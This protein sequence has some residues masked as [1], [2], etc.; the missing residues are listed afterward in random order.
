MTRIG[1]T[2][3]DPVTRTRG[4]VVPG[5]GVPTG[6]A[7][8]SIGTRSSRVPNH[9]RI[10]SAGPDP[11][12][13]RLGPPSSWYQPVVGSD[14]ARYSGEF[15]RAV[16][17]R[18]RMLAVLLALTTLALLA[19]VG[20]TRLQVARTSGPRPVPST[21]TVVAVL[22]PQL[23][24][25]QVTTPRPT[26]ERY[27]VRAGDTLDRIAERFG[28]AVPAIVA[29]NRL[30]TPDHLTIGQRLVIPA[31]PRLRVDEVTANS[32]GVR[33]RLSVPAEAQ[34]HVGF[35]I[36]S[37]VGAYTGPTHPADADGR[38]RALYDAPPT[39]GRYEVTATGD[40]GTTATA[41]FDLVP[42]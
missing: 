35:T 27:T 8:E 3:E 22:P 1:P 33:V 17:R 42:G 5:G 14:D 39:P 7:G 37:P 31:A 23:T 40:R 6:W 9:E 41:A 13:P 30:T 32:S 20:L 4:S 19:V 10:R 25:R 18:R 28:R 36:R 11:I 34:E 2:R 21:G 16:R 12:H 29:R 26:D 38:V 15:A 24:L